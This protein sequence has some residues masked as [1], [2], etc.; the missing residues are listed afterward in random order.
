MR[1]GVFGGTFDPPHVGHL[2]VAQEVWEALGLERLL[3]VP[4]AIPPH[5]AGIE[6]TPGEIRLRMLRAA[7]ADDPRFEVSELELQRPGLSYTVDT[8]REL[9]RLHAGAELFFIMGADQLAAFASWRAPEEVARLA[10][11]VVIG[12][13]GLEA[14]DVTPGI[15][16]EYRALPV[17]RVD[18]SAREIRE[19]VRQGRSIRYMVPDAVRRIIEEE[20]LYVTDGILFHA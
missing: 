17:T 14:Q 18:V 12:R 7:T 2:I 15:A 8:L 10:R 6:V 3:F 11:L 13:R 16:V 9:R 1:L 20:G 19:R 5:K 4:A